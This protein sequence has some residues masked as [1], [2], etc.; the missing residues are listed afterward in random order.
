VVNRV[1]NN[2]RELITEEKRGSFVYLNL[3]K[4]IIDLNPD[5]DTILED[6]GEKNN[7]SE[8]NLLNNVC[9][10]AT[11]RFSRLVE[12]SHNWFYRGVIAKSSDDKKRLYRK[13][14]DLLNDCLFWTL[15][16][17][18]HKCPSTNKIYQIGFKKLKIKPKHKSILALWKLIY[19]QCKIYGLD[20]ISK[21][22]D[23]SHKN[24]IGKTIYDDPILHDR[25][26]T[27]KKQLQNFYE[28]YIT[29]TIFKYQLLK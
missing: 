5:W 23:T 1:Y 2:I 28:K 26:D 19:K 4:T 10:F 21:K 14:T 6:K 18:Q 11:G 29:Q 25:I 22:F 3:N 15:L 12:M 9:L 27:L 20:N 13:D 7:T 16:T 8:K 24:L 17:N